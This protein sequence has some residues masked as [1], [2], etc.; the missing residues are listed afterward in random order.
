[1]LLSG[2]VGLSNQCVPIPPTALQPQRDMKL[3]P[4]RVP[5]GARWRYHEV[6]IA[7]WSLKRTLLRRWTIWVDILHFKSWAAAALIQIGTFSAFQGPHQQGSNE[8]PRGLANT[9][10][11]APTADSESSINWLLVNMILKF[12]EPRMVKCAICR[13]PGL[14]EPKFM[15]TCQLN[16][17]KC[18]VTIM[19]KVFD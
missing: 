19:D 16:K 2:V 12:A 17:W 11:A 1:M 14:P 7:M 4:K 5:S 3:P 6:S 13:P 9:C 18:F 15:P 8:V 10:S